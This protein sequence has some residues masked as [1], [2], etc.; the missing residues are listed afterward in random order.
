MTT[1]GR[2]GKESK[3]IEGEKG[4]AMDRDLT[5]GVAK[6]RPSRL[7]VLIGGRMIVALNNGYEAGLR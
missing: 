1:C 5:A 7:A 3:C 4:I 6:V 2:E